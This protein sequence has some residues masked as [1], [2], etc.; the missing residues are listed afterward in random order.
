VHYAV[1]PPIDTPQEWDVLQAWLPEMLE[2]RRD[3]E[4]FHRGHRPP[5]NQRGVYLF[6]DHG[7]HLY[8]GRTGITARTRLLGIRST[9]TET[10]VHAMLG[11]PYNDFSPS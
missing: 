10:Y 4:V 11:T 7:R 1:A 9:I 2:R 6:T 8:V 5:R 3:S